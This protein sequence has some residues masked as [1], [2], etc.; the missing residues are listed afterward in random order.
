MHIPRSNRTAAQ[1]GARE[2]EG[3]RQGGKVI[4]VQGREP[5]PEEEG[6]GARFFP[7]PDKLG[8]GE[9]RRRATSF[10]LSRPGNSPNLQCR[11]ILTGEFLTLGG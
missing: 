7:P 3:T 1:P 5:N 10:S 11:Q 9:G 4:Y 8:G 6:S 2:G